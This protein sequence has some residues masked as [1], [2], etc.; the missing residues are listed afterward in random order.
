MTP[1][2][3]P[4]GARSASSYPGKTVLLDANG[5]YA[6]VSSEY[7]EGRESS[8]ILLTDTGGSEVL[9]QPAPAWSRILNYCASPDGKYL[10]VETTSPD[11]ASDQYP[12]LPGSSPMKTVFVNLTSGTSTRSVS[13]FLPSWCR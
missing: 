12:N 13:G 8:R 4:D 5:R 7:A 10:A 11:G 6:Q 2:D 1:L 9:Y 3:L